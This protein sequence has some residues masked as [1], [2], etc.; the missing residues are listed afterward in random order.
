MNKNDQYKGQRRYENDQKRERKDY[1]SNSHR[2][3]NNSDSGRDRNSRSENRSGSG[4]SNHLKR[5]NEDADVKY[6]KRRREEEDNDYTL[7]PDSKIEA[8]CLKV[9]EGLFELDI[10]QVN[11]LVSP[12]DKDSNEPIQVQAL[13]NQRLT[14]QVDRLQ[15]TPKDLFI[16]IVRREKV[17]DLYEALRTFCKVERR[18]VPRQIYQRFL[19]ECK[20]REDSKEKGGWLEGEKPLDVILPTKGERSIELKRGLIE[21]FVKEG[22][23]K[24]HAEEIAIRICEKMGKESRAL[25]DSFEAEWDQRVKRE[26]YKPLPKEVQARFMDDKVELIFDGTKHGLNLSHYLKFK[27]LFAIHS[28]PVLRKVL[29]EKRLMRAKKFGIPEETQMIPPPSALPDEEAKVSLDDFDSHELSIFHMRLF[30]LIQ[31]Y[32][33]LSINEP[34]GNGSGFHAALTEKVFTYLTRAFGVEM[35]CFASPFNCHFRTFCSV[36]PDTDQWFGSLGSFFDFRP[37]QG[38]FE[39]NPPFL[40]DLM[41]EGAQRMLEILKKGDHPVSF[42]IVLPDWTRPPTPCITMLQGEPFREF[43]RN[44]Q[45]QPKGNDE[46]LDG[47][48]HENKPRHFVAPW[49]GRFFFVQNDL[50]AKTWE[51]TSPLVENLLLAFSSL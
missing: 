18:Q 19:F 33:C 5:H 29:N 49:D 12:D 34:T 6:E 24:V 11:V 15:L 21:A 2:N 25:I 42:F 51:I 20:F 23:D 10:Y 36:F 39:W 31:R 3:N 32:Y 41:K 37:I 22:L 17:M 47:Y 44:E 48:Q 1:Y 45:K 46:W 27:K 8:K 26:K 38:S 43:L 28:L 40:E 50:G 7:T 13:L 14:K 30:A 9:M 4:S 16:E 35:E